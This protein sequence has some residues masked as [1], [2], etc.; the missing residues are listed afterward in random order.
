MSL[1]G[2]V[3]GGVVSGGIKSLLSGKGG[4]GDDYEKMKAMAAENRRDFMKQFELQRIAER[5]TQRAA[6]LSAIAKAKHD[7]MMIIANNIK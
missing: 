1:I 7:A 2:S 4:E 3:V 5:D 6:T